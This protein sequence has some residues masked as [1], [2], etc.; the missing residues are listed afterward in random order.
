VTTKQELYVKRAR[1]RGLIKVC[2]YVPEEA[3][4][5]IVKLAEKLRRLARKS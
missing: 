3:R 4:E 2:V 5:S 1:K